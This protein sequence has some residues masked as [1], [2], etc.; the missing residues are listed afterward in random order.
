[1]RRR[2]LSGQGV[3]IKRG[4]NVGSRSLVQHPGAREVRVLLGAGERQRC[5]NQKGDRQFRDLLLQGLSPS[6]RPAKDWFKGLRSSAHRSESE[7]DWQVNPTPIRFPFHSGLHF[8]RRAKAQRLLAPRRNVG[9]G[10]APAKADAIRQA[11]E[12]LTIY[13]WRGK[14][15]AGGTSWRARFLPGEA[16]PDGF[17]IY[18]VTTGV[19]LLVENTRLRSYGHR[20]PKIKDVKSGEL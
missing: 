20:E 16:A 4:R 2:L 17:C 18:N 7:N 11:T 12:G 6:A 5:A 9:P 1:L 13:E 19:K 15:A 8:R 10:L 14:P 3:V